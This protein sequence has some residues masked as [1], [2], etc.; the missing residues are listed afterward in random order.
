MR[1]PDV[2]IGRPCPE[3]DGGRI[4]GR[5]DERCMSCWARVVMGITHYPRSHQ[6]MVLDPDDN[7][8]VEVFPATRE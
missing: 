5:Y 1:S 4:Y 7:E 8:T 3:C 6:T 2:E